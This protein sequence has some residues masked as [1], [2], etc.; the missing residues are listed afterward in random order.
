[1]KN[2]LGILAAN[3]GAGTPDFDERQPRFIIT[4][5]NGDRLL[6]GVSIPRREIRVPYVTSAAAPA[7]GVPDPASPS[8][9]SARRFSSRSA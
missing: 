9:A 8:R 1:V 6:V 2:S 5:E 4:R 3:F 7:R